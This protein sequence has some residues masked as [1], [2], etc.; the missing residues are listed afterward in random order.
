MT[1]TV[2][3]HALAWLVVGLRRRRT[4]RLL[5]WGVVAA[6]GLALLGVILLDRTVDLLLGLPTTT[7]S[8]LMA[9]WPTEPV[10][11]ALGTAVVLS[12]ALAAWSVGVMTCGWALRRTGDVAGTDPAARP[13]KRVSHN[14][15]LPRMLRRNER[16]G[17][18]RSA[19]L[20]R[21]LAVIVLLP[22]AAAMIARLPWDSL[23]LLPPLVGSGAA[24]LY[25]VNA[26]ALEG[27]GSMLFASSPLPHRTWLAAKARV[28]LEVVGLAV[29]V[30]VVAGSVRA[31]VPTPLDVMAVACSALSCTLLVVASCLHL[32]VTRPHRAE[33]RGPRDTP[34]PPGTMALYSVRLATM[35]TLV[36]L[37]FALSSIAR[38]WPALLLM[39][40]A[41]LLLAA[42]SWM[43]TR[44]RWDD[45]AVRARVVA[46]VST[47]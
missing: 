43:R 26:F 2:A 1:A 28:V 19:P 18:L 17:V 27:S 30:A 25:G 24:L 44:K 5:V 16:N 34:A 21:G 33:L 23:V 22:A 35:T 12:L 39:S 42:R 15:D 10:R 9:A 32:S 29:V 20:R 45:P 40:A 13:V 11:A 8:D 36:S 37:G 31:G 14:G 6:S 46:T 41:T 3:G 7:V 4:G 47:G 38:S